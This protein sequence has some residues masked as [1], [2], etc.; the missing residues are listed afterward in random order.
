MNWEAI[1]A[2]AELIGAIGVIGSLVYLGKQIQSSSDNVTQNTKALIS[3]R[4]ISSNEF[5]LAN[6][7]AQIENADV[8][9]LVLKGSAE[10]HQLTDVERLRYSLVLLG[11][12]ESHQTFFVQKE[13]GSVSPE[14]WDYYSGVFDRLC[15]TPGVSLFW[16]NR[17]T[18]FI[19]AFANYIDQKM[20]PE[21]QPP[22]AD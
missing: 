9:A 6:L 13:G 22:V 3:N 12:F 4:D 20:P 17:R 5:A 2:I 14:L 1:G 18:Q 19:P 21:M 8:A 16:K 7:R 10:P 15:E 11:M